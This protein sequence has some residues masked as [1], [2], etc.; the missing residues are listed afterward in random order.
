MAKR[1]VG[2][3]TDPV[4]EMVMSGDAKRVEELRQL[5][6]RHDWLY[7]VQARPEVSD[8]Q[9]DRLMAE[10]KALE[11]ANPA[12][13]TP[14]SPTQ[15][16][17]G[18]P[19]DGFTPVTHAV[20]MLSI[21]NTYSADDVRQFDARV[22]KAVGSETFHYLVD[23]KIDGVAVVLRYE[24]GQLLLAGSRGDGHTGDDVTANI[25]T[26]RS[27]PLS[28]RGDGIPDVLEVRGEV[29]WPQGN[30]NAYNSARAKQGIETFANPR[31]GAAGTLKQLDPK[32][33]A[34]R[35]LAFIAHGLGEM[36]VRSA[37][38]ANEVMK[39]I[40]QWGIPTSRHAKVCGSIGEVLA[41]ISDWLERRSEVD[42][43]TDGMVVKVDEL[44]LRRRL[45]A[46]SKYPR[47]CI[48]YKYE[49]EQTQTVL[50]SVDFQVGRLGTI[51]P[52]A[53]FDPV[54]LG[55]TT[56]SNASLHNFDQVRRLDVH[57]GDTILV[58]K[59]GEIIPQVRQVVHE[60][61]L[62]KV[63]A[64]YPPK[65]CPSCGQPTA[66][67]EGGVYLRCINHECPA[68]LRE[69]LLFFA[70]RGQMDIESLGPAV[71]DQL[72]SEALVT[73]FA[74]LYALNKRDLMALERMGDKSSENLLAAIETSKSRDLARLI[75][76][77]GIRHV[78]G[79]MAEVLAGQFGD[80]VAVA[81]A[82]VEI[83]TEINE[84][85]PVI[86]ASVF[87]FFHSDAGIETVR[88]LKDA[89]VRMTAAKPR[90]VAA[91][92]MGGK[93]VVVTGAMEDFSRS[94]AQAAI[95]AAGGR[96]VSSVSAKTDFVVVG[97]SP[98]SK[99][100]KAR[101][102]GVEIINEKEFKRRLGMT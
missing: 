90:G 22:R 32:I 41:T 72:V 20:P 27:V 18:Q 83:L 40:A 43:Q 5:I 77:L 86:A 3:L 59:A 96:A 39:R 91:A 45:G 98:G 4:W 8:R 61:R 55:G 24:A 84:I 44:V 102:L 33:V 34:Q 11:A 101:S 60:K 47:W 31:N 93:T 19:I 95:K 50:R 64:I 68:Q 70:G 42:Y 54:Q 1:R 63:K 29:Y 69:R 65:S 56:I 85:G 89:G 79:R 97:D 99:V 81:S 57:V 15:R 94:E 82:S 7:Y 67:D 100:D 6:C 17:A 9:Y 62:D 49:S 14:D 71:V 36:S 78:G 80:I 73:H 2:W 35:K 10:L 74:D 58:E 30:F 75:A 28:L 53:H 37:D 48:A 66:R 26:I 51:T 92:M 12:L 46:T 23:P 38:R 87:A 88:R 52:T 76:A 13:V 25:R 16:V 21:D